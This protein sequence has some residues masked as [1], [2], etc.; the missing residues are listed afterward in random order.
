MSAENIPVELTVDHLQKIFGLS[1]AS[2]WH[3]VLWPYMKKYD[4]DDVNSL[5]GGVIE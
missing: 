2:D 5:I 3:S 1:N 4:I